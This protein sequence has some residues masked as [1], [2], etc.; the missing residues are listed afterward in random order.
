[1]GSDILVTIAEFPN[2]RWHIWRSL[3][4]ARAI[5]NQIP[6][7]ACNRSGESPDSSFF[8]GSLIVN[9]LGD[10]IAEAGENESVIFGTI[11]L[12]KTT[13]IRNEIPVFDDRRAELY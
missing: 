5:E 4:I 10:V 6:H 2:P 9:Q 13:K 1:M 12:E 11:D 3:A 8:G 7:I